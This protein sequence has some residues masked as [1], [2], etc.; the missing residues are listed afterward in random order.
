MPKD[1]KDFSP[2]PDILD[3]MNEAKVFDSKGELRPAL[4]KLPV[5]HGLDLTRLN[6]VVVDMVAAVAGK[7]GADIELLDGDEILIPR[8][9]DTAMVIG[10]TATPF[11]IYK[12]AT[13]MTVK[14]LL[15][16]AGGTTR[17]ADTWNLRLLK[18]DGRIMDRWVE[19]QAVEPG[20]V[21]LVPQVV[22]RV[23]SWQEDLTAMTP[24]AILINAFRR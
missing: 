13:G 9:T 10:E 21:V 20:D 18:A 7:A 1:G 15:R 4:F 3:R 12:V 23:G 14:D 11:A 2:I 19:R 22:R 6:R 5:L 16:T 17:N 24:L 8:R